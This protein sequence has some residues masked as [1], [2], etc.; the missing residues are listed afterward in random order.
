MFFLP[1]RR[2]IE[3]CN[4]Q[5]GDQSTDRL[6]LLTD[7]LKLMTSVH[8]K[9]KMG[10]KKG[11]KEKNNTRRG[12]RK[13]EDKERTRERNRKNGGKER[14]KEGKNEGSKSG[15]VAIKSERKKEKGKTAAVLFSIFLQICLIKVVADV[16]MNEV[17]YKLFSDKIAAFDF[18][19]L[20]VR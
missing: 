2:L 10:K 17:I 8:R 1:K 13:Q 16:F 19:F 14:S 18:V 15:E 3:K 7:F 11:K 9:L 4:S 5:E 6:D 20:S 12:R